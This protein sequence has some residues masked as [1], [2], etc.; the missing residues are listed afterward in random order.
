VSRFFDAP[1]DLAK[2]GRQEYD[3]FIFHSF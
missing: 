1:F 2:G 3:N